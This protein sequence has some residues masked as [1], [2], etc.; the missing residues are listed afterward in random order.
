MKVVLLEDIKGKGK[1]GDVVNVSD[2]YAKNFLFVK[3]LAAPENKQIKNDF[4]GK[5]QSEQYKLEMQKKEALEIKEKLDSKVLEFKVNGSE[6]G[7][8]FGSIT[9]KEVASQIKEQLKVDIDKKKLVMETI[10]SYGSYECKAKLFT[11]IM[12]TFTVK[13]VK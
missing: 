3:G 12:A 1:K 11:G 6:N 2:G 10:K 13:I 8:L 4:A 5:A 7:K 9:T